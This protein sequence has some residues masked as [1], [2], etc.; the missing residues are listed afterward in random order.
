[1]LVI[2]S[3]VIIGLNIFQRNLVDTFT[4]LGPD[5]EQH[6]AVSADHGAGVEHEG[7]AVQAEVE[8]G[9]DRHQQRALSAVQVLH[10]TVSQS[11]NNHWS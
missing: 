7:G 2:G 10:G 6:A 11:Y 1:M 8:V 5:A 9:G 3:L 4:V